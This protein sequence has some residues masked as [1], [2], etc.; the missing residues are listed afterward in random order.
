[1]NLPTV[2]PYRRWDVRLAKSNV[3]TDKVQVSSQCEMCVIVN[4]NRSLAFLLSS[5]G[6]GTLHHSSFCITSRTRHIAKCNNTAQK[7][8]EKFR[9]T[10]SVLCGNKFNKTCIFLGWRV[11]IIQNENVEGHTRICFCYKNP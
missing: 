2:E 8:G 11:A 5:I 6:Y 7:R 9:I 1:V 3:V 10:G 4:N